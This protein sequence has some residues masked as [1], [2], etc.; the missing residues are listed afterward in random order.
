[1]DT[2]ANDAIK[3]V[4]EENWNLTKVVFLSKA[5]INALKETGDKTYAYLTHFNAR[6]IDQRS[7]YIDKQGRSSFIGPG[8][9]NSVKHN[10]TAFTFSFCSYELEIFNKKNKLQSVTEI[11]FA[12]GEL[13]KIDYLFLCQQLDNLIGSAS[14][15]VPAKEYYNVERNIKKNENS[16]LILLSDFFREKDIKKM[17]SFYENEY[18]LVDMEKYQDIILS[19]ESGKG[20]V[21]I[22]WSH[23]HK[24]YM[25]T[26]VNAEDGAVISQMGFGG[27]KFGKNHDANDIIK[28]KHLSYITSKMAQKINNKY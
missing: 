15:D 8:P 24:M 17:D 27:I 4:F 3:E 20:Y 2:Y 6:Q 7:M 26:V 14:K 13:L 16:K 10:Y 21:K 11:G 19:K 5:E 1:M 22:I 23:H 18:E 28:A 9:I 12:N 25:W